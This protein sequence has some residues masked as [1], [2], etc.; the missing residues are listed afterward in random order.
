MVIY[1]KQELRLTSLLSAI[2]F[3]SGFAS[4]IYQVS[5]QRLL[6]VYYGVGTISIT[7]IVSVYML[8]LRAGA[9]WGGRLAERIQDKIALYFIVE[10]LLGCFGM[11]S[12]FLL[13]LLG[14]YTAGSSLII[15]FFCMF[16]FLCMPTVLM[17]ITLPLLTKIFNGF[18]QDFF[19]SVSFLY[20]I[21]TLGAALGALCAS[22]II[23][24][25]FG[26]DISVYSA[27]VINFILAGMIFFV[28]HK[29]KD[30]GA[31]KPELT[32]VGDND[33]LLVTT[34]YV[35]VF[36]TG[37]L[38]I[39]YEIA[40]FRV[41]GV[42]VKNSP[43]A[44]SSVLAIYLLGIALGSFGMTKY[45]QSTKAIKNKNLFF[46]IQVFI[47]L[48]VVIIFIGYYYLTEY[49]YLKYFTKLSFRRVLHPD[50]FSISF[51]SLEHGL[52]SFY[53]LFD[54]FFWAGVFVFIP[55]I[56]MGASFPLISF[57][58]LSDSS[59]EGKT[60]GTIYFF[61]I[62][63]NVLGGL[64]TGLLLLPYFGTER[65][66]LL[67]SLIGMLFILFIN[68]YAG[69]PFAFK[70]RIAVAVF[71][72]IF[73]VLFFPRGGALYKIMHSSP[74]A[75]YKIFLDEGIDGV[76]LTYQHQDRVITYINGLPHGG[77]PGYAFYYEAIQAATHAKD[78][79]DVLVIGYGTGSF[80]DVVLKLDDAKSITIVELSH[81]LMKNLKKIPLFEE[82]LSDPRVKL[83]FD[84]GRRFLLQTKK[85]YDLIMMD[86]LRSSTSYSN[87]LYSHQFFEL[88]KDHLKSG[89][90][91]LI[92]MDEDMVI[93]KTIISSFP[94]VKM[95]KIFSLASNNLFYKNDERHNK[96]WAR[97]SPHE[98][99]E[100][101]INSRD[102]GTF[103]GD[104]TY[105][106]EA[107]KGYQ[108]NS[109]WKPLC[110]Y[111]LGL[112]IRNKLLRK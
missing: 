66:V 71:C 16:V 47:S 26:L 97:F 1:N 18:I 78:V 22:Y 9:L 35:I 63:G 95:Y 8:G 10:L 5:W 42:L 41:V 84:D 55:T 14:H 40:W 89:G 92:W 86:P 2:F 20:F 4:L 48:Y 69:K 38:A 7:L 39:G 56:L 68:Q 67:F 112:K 52:L 102:M 94:Y 19:K 57:L 12:L 11:F 53:A 77:R 100:M 27:A 99:Q 65:T 98:Q 90:I 37:F 61:N 105:I 50:L 24:S 64:L 91:V 21:N 32:P 83:I 72:V 29:A 36:V 87:N 73:S 31:S 75:G 15:S 33:S 76:I 17:G 45:V 85:K 13:D 58:A 111:Y 25:F 23:I 107:T 70:K 104:Q 109:D 93:P 34:A 101:E 3:F 6:T 79:N 59:Q 51:K 108:I 96:L 110:E 74:G 30:Q 49:S 54:V 103:I 60:V 28:R 106:K 44:F 46:T 62:L 80:V 82:M 43:Y 88:L 81:T